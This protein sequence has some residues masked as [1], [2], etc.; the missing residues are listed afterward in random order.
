MRD[1]FRFI[2]HELF[3]YSIAALLKNEKFKIANIFLTQEYM[4]R[5][6]TADYVRYDDYAGTFSHQEAI[7][8]E[9]ENNQTHAGGWARMLKE[10]STHEELDFR[11]LQEADL[12]L[13]LRDLLHKTGY[14]VPWIPKTLTREYHF[15]AFELFARAESHRY[16]DALKTLLRVEN[17]E[18]LATKLDAAI[19]RQPFGGLGLRSMNLRTMVN[20]DSLDTRP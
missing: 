7:T 19:K 12:V 14:S 5:S 3:L 18:E 8:I 2:S 11:R 15:S 17:K 9:F 6:G 1:N 4:D 16:F 10:R 13:F 20:L